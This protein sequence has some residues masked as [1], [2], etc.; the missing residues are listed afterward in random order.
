MERKIFCNGWKVKEIR[1]AVQEESV[2]SGVSDEKEMERPVTLP[3][4][5]MQ[6]QGRDA[7]AESGSGG[8]FF[9]GGCYE[10]RNMWNVPAKWKDKIIYLEFEGVYPNAEVYVNGVKTGEGKYGYSRF[11]VELKDLQYGAENEIKVIADNS[12]LPNSRWYSGAGIYRPV[13]ILCGNKTHILPDGIRVTTLSYNPAVIRIETAYA[14]ADSGNPDMKAVEEVGTERIKMDGNFGKK[15][16]CI[17]VEIF[18]QDQK[19][20]EGKGANVQLEIPEAHLWDAENPELY[21]CRVTLKEA[22]ETVDR[23][24]TKFGIRSLGWSA[25]NGLTVNGKTVLLKGGCIHHDNGILGARSYEESEWRKIARLKEYGFNAVRSAHNPMCPAALEACDRLGMYVMDET[26]DMW[27]KAKNPEDYAKDFMENYDKDL[28]SI[29]E[30]DYNHPSVILYSI[31]NEVTEPAKE[32]GVALATEIV[33]KLKSLDSTRP[34]TAGINLTLLLLATME[35]NPMEAGNAAA[36]DT[37]QINSTAYN[38]M[39]S[40]MGNRMTMAAATEPADQVSAPVF[41]LLDI[42]GYNYADSRY[43]MEGKVHPNRIVVGSE[44]YTYDLAKRWKQVEMYPYLIGDFMWTAWDYLGEAGIGSWSYDPECIGF[45]KEYPWLLADTGALDILGNETAAA[46]AAA[47]IWGARKSPYIGVKPVNHPGV[48]PSHAIWRGTNAMPY[49]SY[50]NCE[51]NE[52]EVEVYS[53]AHEVELLINGRSVGRNVLED[54]KAEFQIP[55]ESGELK[56][57]AY[58]ADGSIYS[59]STLTSADHDVQIC[60]RQEACAVKQKMPEKIQE[61]MQEKVVYLDIS[62][63]GA[64]GEIECNR[65]TQLHVEMEGGELLAFGSAN[66][67]TKEDFLI[68]NYTTYYGRSQAVVKVDDD[69]AVVRVSGGGMEAVKQ[70]TL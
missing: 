51:G 57:V 50:Q 20:A 29:V 42:A 13:W 30:K 16:P 33:R 25:K 27:D 12:R 17:D 19:V 61:K 69:S 41:E 62:L 67:R 11:Y 23:Q 8:A 70:I 37:A 65:D 48:I 34:V 4:D 60:I 35:N 49:W 68:G 2:K 53:S 58:N 28:K 39:V 21:E 45:Q 66:P 38:Q 64:N 9:K 63:R 7:Q 14:D 10:Y 44:T 15:E 40:E 59:E 6:E 22:G 26:W 54:Y 52:A 18:F 36:L 1:T 32:S 56:A 43:E 46:G 24:T 3:H 31:G 5:A 47:V 55:Y